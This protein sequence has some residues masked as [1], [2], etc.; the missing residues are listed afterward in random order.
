MKAITQIF[1]VLIRLSLSLCTNKE[2]VNEEKTAIKD[3]TREKEIIKTN[4][5]F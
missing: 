4:E 2:T 3:E 5:S 1:I